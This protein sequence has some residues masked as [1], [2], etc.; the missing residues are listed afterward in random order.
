MKKLIEISKPIILA[1]VTG[2]FV[3]VTI[4]AFSQL[5]NASDIVYCQPSIDVNGDG[6][7]NAAD[8]A[9]VKR[10]FFQ[11]RTSSNCQPNADANGDGVVNIADI[12][13]I[14][15]NFFTQP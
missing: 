4:M 15:E 13:L 12:I 10:D 3:L 11:T 5:A 8:L 1:L 14:R 7:V 2:L 6:I 9:I